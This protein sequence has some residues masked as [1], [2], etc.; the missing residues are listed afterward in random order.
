GTACGVVY[1]TWPAAPAGPSGASSDDTE[2]G[3][4]N[5]GGDP[6]SGGFT[7]GGGRGSTATIAGG[8]GTGAGLGCSICPEFE[9]GAVASAAGRSRWA[10]GL[11]E[12]S[13]AGADLDP[14][15]NTSRTTRS[16]RR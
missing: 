15:S 5:V 4:G 6:A 16:P 9:A 11:P 12:A 10:P 8:T 1:R 14:G 2:A 13:E 7:G 3:A